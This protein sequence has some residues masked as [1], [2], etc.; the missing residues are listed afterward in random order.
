[1]NQKN[2]GDINMYPEYEKINA[3]LQEASL[4]MKTNRTMKDIFDL[5][6]DRNAK[7]VAVEFKNDDLKLK[8]FKYAKLKVN[9]INFAKVIAFKLK[10]VEKNRPVVLKAKNSPEWIES[11]Y[12]IL[13]AGFKPLLIAANTAKE[14][15]ENLINQSKAVAVV[16]DDTFMYDVPKIGIY[17]LLNGNYDVAFTP[18]WENEVIFCSSGTTGDVKL[19]IYNGENLCHQ[20]CASLDMP[21]E[22]KD[23]MY[24]KKF[25]KIK[26]LA[27]VPFHHIFG[28]VA[29]F[30]WYTFYGKTLVFPL[31]NTPSELQGICIK[32]KVSHVYS[33][34]LFWDSLALQLMRKA[35]LEGRKELLEKMV[36]Y[37][38]GRISK[39]EAGKAG[40]GIAKKLVQKKLLGDSVRYCIS[41]GGY[42]SL[43]TLETIN[44]IGYNLY[45]GYGMTE[46]G[47]TSVDMS[48]DINIRLLGSIGH[49]LHGVEYKISDDKELLIKSGTTH[50]REIIGGKEGPAS[51]DKEGYF[52]T[53]DIVEVDEHGGYHIK[54][55]SKD[56][57][58]NEDG[59]NI[60]P[61]E[62]EIFF[63][64]LPNVNNLCVLG[65]SKKNQHEDIVLVLEVNNSV[66]DEALKDLK[67]RIEEIGKNLPKGA[68]ISETYLAKGRLPLANNM[69][70][71]RFAIKKELEADSGDYLPITIKRKVKTFEGF[72]KAEVDATISEV[73]KVFAKVLI[74]PAFKVEDDAHWINDLGGDSMSYVELIKELQERFQITF[75]EE[76]L[77][78]MACVNDFVLEILTLKK[79]SK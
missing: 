72:D 79:S 36:A 75:K 30:L 25:G 24:P 38:L 50:I 64:D 3:F 76:T 74:L 63:K 26:I 54:G 66:D 17:D 68:K 8:K 60:F 58:I 51:L 41:G 4:L 28:F 10:N 14:A 1:M 19:M 11:F 78:Q 37:N 73:R 29:V 13:M 56:V 43:Q 21:K 12:A 34:P 62:L 70:V 47:V 22:T 69:K 6:M 33:V 44:G 32:R 9:T 2:I 39:E 31:D 77:G 67:A 59:E 16:T 61:D 55:R 5:T 42:L 40:L 15:T 71:K 45:N 7:N 48:R 57:I 46:V 27:M 20:I 52:H 23:I 53:G 18:A 65:V 49:P 35:E